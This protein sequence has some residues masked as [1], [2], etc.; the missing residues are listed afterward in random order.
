[1]ESVKIMTDNGNATISVVSPQKES[2]QNAADK[3]CEDIL[4]QQTSLIQ[5]SNLDSLHQR[6]PP[7]DIEFVDLTYTVPIS[8][9]GEWKL[10]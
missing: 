7:I 5:K 2:Y 1:M 3:G 9:N 6:C 8:K 10:L 4:D